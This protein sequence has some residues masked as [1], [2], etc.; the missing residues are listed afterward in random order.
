MLSREFLER[1]YWQLKKSPAQIAEETGTYANA[2]RRELLR[3]WRKLRGR[4]EAQAAALETGRQSHPTAGRPIPP[5]TRDKI[6]EAVSEGY[7]RQDEAAR[8][9]RRE[10]A[11]RAWREKGSQKRRRMSRRGRAAARAARSG[12]RAELFLLEGLRAAGL[13]VV[14]RGAHGDLLLGERR[15]AVFVDG[16]PLFKAVWGDEQLARLQEAAAAKREAARSAG[17]HAVRVC[18]FSGKP[19]RKLLNSLLK[20]LLIMIEWAA[21]EASPIECEVTA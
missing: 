12:S 21:G 1:E 4:A 19:S 17:L 18:V 2:V 7:E 10:A 6:G 11:R 3:Y 5:E 16:P 8:E 9:G 20:N 15:V 13:D 14:H